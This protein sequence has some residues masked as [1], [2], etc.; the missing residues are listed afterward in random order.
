MES[1]KEIK[2]NLGDEG[3]YSLMIPKD[4]SKE[5]TLAYLDTC[6]VETRMEFESDVEND[7]VEE[8]LVKEQRLH[9]ESIRN[10]EDISNYLVCVGLTVYNE[11][12][13][14]DLQSDSDVSINF[15]YGNDLWPGLP[16]TL[17]KTF[18]KEMKNESECADAMRCL[19]RKVKS[20]LTR[21]VKKIWIFQIK[22]EFY[23]KCCT[24]VSS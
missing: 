8:W 13:P 10:K 20:K 17:I 5:T 15:H 19:I 23:H 21:T 11:G 6:R 12:A 1:K 4:A 2:V 9:F 3:L 16:Q 7:Y 22:M 14:F 24:L 18:P